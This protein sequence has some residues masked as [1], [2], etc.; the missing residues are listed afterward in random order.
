MGHVPAT[1]ILVTASITQG[2]KIVVRRSNVYF[3][4]DEDAALYW[5]KR[6][7]SAPVTNLPVRGGE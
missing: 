7:G 5:G 3:T 1:E 2:D 6:P 4:S